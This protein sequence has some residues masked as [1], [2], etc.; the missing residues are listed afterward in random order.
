[1][2]IAAIHCLQLSKS[3]A[4]SILY[5]DAQPALNGNATTSRVKFPGADA[6]VTLRTA[7]SENL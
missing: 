4:I 2:L 1:M 3:E 6:D 7:I 5:A